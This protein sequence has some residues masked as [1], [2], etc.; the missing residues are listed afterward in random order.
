VCSTGI[1]FTLLKYNDETNF[2]PY[3]FV[4]RIKLCMYS[5]FEHWQSGILQE[6]P[7]KRSDGP[8]K[9]WN[10]CQQKCGNHVVSVYW[11][12]LTAGCHID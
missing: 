9:S 10:F 2:V 12:P 11:L 7:R 6:L 1:A 5:I 3:A 4:H 8:K